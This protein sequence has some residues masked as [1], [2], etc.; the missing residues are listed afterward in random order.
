[1]WCMQWAFNTLWS[2]NKKK[3]SQIPR[4][5]T[6]GLILSRKIEESVEVEGLA[7]V[8]HLMVHVVRHC[9]VLGDVALVVLRMVDY[10]DDLQGVRRDFR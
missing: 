3:A 7:Q 2:A 8:K 1:M 9:A 6:L 5:L 4:P 10:F